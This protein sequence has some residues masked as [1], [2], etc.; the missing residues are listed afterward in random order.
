MMM[1]IIIMAVIMMIWITKLIIIMMLIER[2]LLVLYVF[3]AKNGIKNSVH[4]FKMIVIKIPVVFFSI[5]QAE[6][7]HDP[8]KEEEY[9]QKSVFLAD[10]NQENV[11]SI[12]EIFKNSQFSLQ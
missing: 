3:N 2:Y 10:I 12:L 4:V 9:R 8:L 6:Y 5:V 1:M 7:W 11:S